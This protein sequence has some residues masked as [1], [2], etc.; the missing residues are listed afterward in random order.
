M[1]PIYTKDE[2]YLF[3]IGIKEN[4]VKRIFEKPTLNELGVHC[5]ED[6]VGNF[7]YGGSLMQKM[8]E[9]SAK[10]LP[11]TSTGISQHLQK[12]YVL[13]QQ[14]THVASDD[15]MKVLKLVSN[16]YMS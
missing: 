7:V 12:V 9:L 15:V 13:I 5:E 8:L 16:Y 1:K 6:R 11:N 4:E 10:T 3:L 14:S 2:F